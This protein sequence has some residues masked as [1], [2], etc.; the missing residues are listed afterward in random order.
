MKIISFDPGYER[1]GIA[2]IEKNEKEREC[3]VFS[4]CFKTKKE[5]SH[6][7]RL[8]L[9]QIEIEKILKEY[10]PTEMAIEKL[11]FSNN[12]KTAFMVAEARG[13]MISVCKTSGLTVSEYGPGEIKL[14]ITGYGKSDKNSVIKMI[15]HLIKI[16][17]EK[18][19]NIKYDDEFDAIAVG[20]THL[21]I[22]K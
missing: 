6:H 15:T 17:S 10:S 1:L 13:V 16:D 22:R 9:I 3:L 18:I 7:E 20:L 14:A 8:S 19:N 21:A 2:I 5:L 11:F 12:Q 4:E